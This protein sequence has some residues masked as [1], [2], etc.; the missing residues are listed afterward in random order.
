MSVSRR[1]VIGALAPAAVF[2]L[3]A[4]AARADGEGPGLGSAEPFSFD[5]LE[6]RAKAMARQPFRPPPR[7]FA[8]RRATLDF[9]AIDQIRYRPDKALWR[10]L[11]GD[12]AVEF[13]HLRR[14]FQ[15][16]VSLH[17]VDRDQAREILYSEALFEAADGKVARGLPDG[18][19]FA[20]FRVMNRNGQGDWVAYLGASYFRAATPFNQFG[21]SARGLAL[22]TA[23]QKPEEFP[24]FTAFW[25]DHDA[26]GDLLVHALLEGPSVVG[27]YR[28][29]HRKAS[30]GLI[31]EIEAS[32]NFRAP[33]QRL[34]LAPLTSM[35]WYGRTDHAKA[36]DWRPQVHD[37]DGLAL[38]TGA[39]ERIWRPLNN[40]PRVMTNAFQ[41]TN[42]RG[43]GLMQRD[44][45]FHD[46]E[47]DV[48]FYDRRPSVWVEPIGSWGR[49]SVGLVEI[50]TRGENDD[51]VVAFWTPERSVK[52]GD[53]LAL[54]YRLHWSAQEPTPV[55][56][57]KVTATWTGVGGGPGQ[58]ATPGVRRFVV[59]FAGGRL[60]DLDHRSGVRPVVTVSNGRPLTPI[61]YPVAGT[62]RWRLLFDVALAAGN[63]ID[64]RAFL[65]LNADSLT[66]TWI[67]QAFG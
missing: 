9:D 15:S 62:D 2:A 13:F 24:S 39:G 55:G 42:P 59:D 32:L 23:T 14:S 52:A 34:G 5:A 25:L 49:G 54:A 3:A 19:G 67:Y 12:S 30:N 47:D 56:V 48:A 16:P 53:S 45:E 28:I 40:P 29:A 35:F 21:L 11:P 44:R 46:Y 51:N 57:A 43:F 36:A 6:T 26:G 1:D 38:W 33:A 7:P 37:S 22:D 8:D 18:L 41:D 65:R 31:Q 10:D 17:L 60:G 4:A 64:L 50:P 61:A 27:A 58:P 20:G 63:T 66:E